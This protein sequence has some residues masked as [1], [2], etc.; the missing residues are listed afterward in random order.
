MSRLIALLMLVAFAF[1]CG[2]QKLT[3]EQMA[4][5]KEAIK[6]VIAGFNQAYQAKDLAGVMKGISTSAEFMFLGTDSAEI[7]KSQ[8]DFENQ[9]KNDWQAFESVQ[10]GEIRNLSV[11]VSNDGELASAVYEVPFDVVIGGQSAHLLLRFGH[12]LKKENGQWRIAQGLA[13]AA[14]VGQSSAEMVAK[15][16]EAKK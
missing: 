6:A 2:P 16:Q 12:G 14:T 11:Q 8:T 4:Q 10:V 7:I 13:A 15:M 9:M 5:E 3:S 1:G